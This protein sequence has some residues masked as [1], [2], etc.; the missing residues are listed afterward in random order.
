MLTNILLLGMFYFGNGYSLPYSDT[1]VISHQDYKAVEGDS[2]TD[3][4]NS[5]VFL[6]GNYAKGLMNGDVV[7]VTYLRDDVII[8]VKYLGE[9]Q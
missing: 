5:G 2:L 1:Y 4:G 7:K 6:D 8:D 9:A 3:G